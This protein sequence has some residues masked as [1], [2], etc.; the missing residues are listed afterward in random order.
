MTCWQTVIFMNRTAQSHCLL[1][2]LSY[3]SKCMVLPRI[4]NACSLAKL[5]FTDTG[6]MQ[7]HAMHVPSMSEIYLG[8][9]LCIINPG[10]N[11]E[12]P[13]V[14]KQWLQ[15][16]TVL[17]IHIPANHFSQQKKETL[18]FAINYLTLGNAHTCGHF[19]FQLLYKW[20]PFKKK[21][22]WQQYLWIEQP[23]VIAY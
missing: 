8:S 21:N 16:G 19:C 23:K 20:K 14:N 18:D 4:S 22:D 12:M 15:A 11:Y 13:I 3:Q 10:D 17:F 7:G 9:G 2:W 5:Y 1:T 6:N